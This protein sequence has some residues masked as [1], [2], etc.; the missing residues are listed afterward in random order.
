MGKKRSSSSRSRRPPEPQVVGPLPL[1]KSRLLR[2]ASR[3][4]TWQGDFHRA[5]DAFPALQDV[6]EP[7]FILVASE[8]SRL[9]HLCQIQDA[10]PTADELW[11]LMVQ[12]MQESLS[13]EPQRP[14]LLRVGDDPLWEQLRSHLDEI[15]VRLETKVPMILLDQVLGEMMQHLATPPEPEA[16]PLLEVPG[17]G[18]PEAASYYDA[19]AYFYREAPWA[20]LEEEGAI[21]IRCPQ[22]SDKPCY[23]VIMGQGG[24]T[25]GLALY[26]DLDWLRHIWTEEVSESEQV[27]G[28][29]ATALTYG[30][31]GAILKEDVAA[32]KE[33]AWKPANSKAYP[34]AYHTERGMVMRTPNAAEYR[35]LEVCLRAVP[36][37][38]KKRP[39]DDTTP[40]TIVVIS[41]SG[42]ATLTL[43]WVAI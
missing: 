24:M 9:V 35:L 39:Q 27:A 34:E 33:H 10:P 1:V 7:W 38:S 25:Y 13:E 31:K 43:S 16:I 40:E 28:T 11:D 26:D 14:V 15:G 5:P 2:L 12:A 41:P 20:S 36:P 8:T 19:A 23:A 21:E 3:G 37:F 6:D 22:L 29:V 42:P 17:M 4:E 32:M 18:I 30:P